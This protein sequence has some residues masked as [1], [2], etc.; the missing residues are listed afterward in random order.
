MKKALQ[1][2]GPKVEKQASGGLIT[3]HGL[4]NQVKAHNASSHG[5]PPMETGLID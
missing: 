2:G 4:F 1:T 3:P 5:N